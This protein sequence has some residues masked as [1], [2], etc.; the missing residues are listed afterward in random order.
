MALNHER[1]AEEA[2]GLVRWLRPEFQ[3]PQHTPEQRAIDT[4]PAQSV[5]NDTPEKGTPATPAS[6][7]VPWPRDA[8]AQVRARAPRRGARDRTGR[9]TTLRGGRPF[10]AR[11]RMATG[12][13]FACGSG[14]VAGARQYR[15]VNRR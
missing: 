12:I 2:R 7:P 14:A 3:N 13:G 10:V 1:A 6:R 11:G 9:Q 5:P 4:G 8:V 15:R